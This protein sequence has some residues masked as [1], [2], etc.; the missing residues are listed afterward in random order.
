MVEALAAEVR[1]RVPAGQAAPGD[2]EAT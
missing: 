2:K 1:R